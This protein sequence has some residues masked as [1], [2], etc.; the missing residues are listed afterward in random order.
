MTEDF[1]CV[2]LQD[3]I[4]QQESS[5]SRTQAQHGCMALSIGL[6]KKVNA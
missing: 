5:I 6:A 2:L 3:G 1:I 4:E